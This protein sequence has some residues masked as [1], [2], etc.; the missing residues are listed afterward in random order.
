MIVNEIKKRN[1]KKTYLWL[2]TF[3]VSS[4]GCRCS[5]PCPSHCSSSSSRR[6]SDRDG[7]GGGVRWPGSSGGV[8]SG[9]VVVV[10]VVALCCI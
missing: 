1:V 6:S 7:H 2:K 9:I 10:G 4:P 5:C 8:A 3:H